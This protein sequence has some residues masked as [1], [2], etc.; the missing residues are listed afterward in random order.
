MRRLRT[1]AFTLPLLAAITL[2]SPAAEAKLVEI[3]GSGLTGYGWGQG[4][5]DATQGDNDFYRW[6]RGGAFGF[7]VGAKILFIG[8]FVD[9]LRWFGGSAGANL[10]TFNLGGDWTIDLSKRWRLVIRG[11]GGYYHGTLPSD[12]TM[13]I[14]G[15]KVTQV[16]TRGV[17]M[18]GGLGLRY[19]FAKV[20]SVGVTPE[21]GYHY[22]F[23]GAEESVTNTDNNSSG[24]DFN[25]LAYFR[26][27]FGF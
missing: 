25:V 9:Y 26:V 11:A 20:F 2:H 24:L 12:A 13:E 8:A 17:G 5:D 23:G 18:R 3:W 14:D 4:Y 21:L 7:E 16:N 22:F 1:L 10:I 6:V 27:G 19:D 15:I